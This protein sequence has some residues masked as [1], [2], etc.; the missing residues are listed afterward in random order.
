MWPFLSLLLRSHTVPE[1]HVTDRH[2]LRKGL[3]HPLTLALR[4]N[5]NA[6]PKAGFYAVKVGKR[7]GIY[8]TWSH[9]TSSFLGAP[10]LTVVIREDCREQVDGYPC[11]T[12]KKLRTVEEAE[13]WMQGGTSQSGPVEQRAAPYPVKPKIQPA[14]HSLDPACALIV[15]QPN[16]HA[17]LSTTS[18]TAKPTATI[19]SDSKLQPASGPSS[20]GL[21]VVAGPSRATPGSSLSAVGEDVVYTDGACSGNGQHGSVAGIGVWWGRKDSRYVLFPTTVL[22]TYAGPWL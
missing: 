16:G 9:F 12:Y 5:T 18:S 17:R 13:A 1:I 7:P 19:Q 10:L 22:S 11:A 4:R 15:P 14:N 6:M 8:T 21:H 2:H 20:P 3:H